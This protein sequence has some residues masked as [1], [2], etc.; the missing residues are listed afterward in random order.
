MFF[1]IGLVGCVLTCLM[2]SR[3]GVLCAQPS[4]PRGNLEQTLQDF[5]QMGDQEKKQLLNSVG[6]D[7]GQGFPWAKVV[8]W[9]LFGSVGFVVFMYGKNIKSFKPLLLGLALM[10]YPYFF[11]DTVWLY[12]IGIALCLGLFLWR[13]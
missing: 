4:I 10:A 12:G 6:I 1:R 9:F 8:A 2:L 13:D 7:V 3:S 5:H 11:N